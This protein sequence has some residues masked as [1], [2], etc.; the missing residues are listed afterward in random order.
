MKTITAIA[1]A[2]L[3]FGTTAQAEEG[4]RFG[5]G[6]SYVSGIEDVTDLYEYNMEFD[7]YYEVDVDM[8]LPVGVAF[9]ADHHW[10][11]GVRLDIGLGP[12]FFI[13][14]DAD[15]FELPV[16]TTVG[17]SFMPNSSV[18][19]YLRA[20]VVHHFVSGDYYN[21]ADP[22]LFAAAGIDF[23]RTSSVKFT[24][25]VATDQSEVEFDTVTCTTPSQFF[26][27]CRPDTVALNTY[28]LLVSLFIKF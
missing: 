1:L 19:P 10:R 23:A 27:S 12:A 4:W 3:A 28:D 14:G 24:F 26:P 18:S 8:V 21:S 20:G 6:P 25:E 7:G 9:A 11:S 15:H 22:G 13:A 5:L 17:F 2:S 16:S